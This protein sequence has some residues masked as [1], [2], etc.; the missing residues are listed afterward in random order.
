[1]RDS[2][3]VIVQLLGAVAIV[4]GFTILFGAPGMLF[5]GGALLVAIGF[6]GEFLS[7]EPLSDD[8][9]EDET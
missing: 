1:M 6:A 4:V 5:S 3:F 7:I 2:A 9:D 8:D